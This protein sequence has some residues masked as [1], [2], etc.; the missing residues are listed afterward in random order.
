MSFEWELIF[1]SETDKMSANTYRGKVIGGWLIS[2]T[3]V[4]GS[5]T[6]IITSQAMTF[7]SDP[8]HEWKIDK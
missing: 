4:T 8:N 3:I 6:N 7:I 5:L 1:D 2:N